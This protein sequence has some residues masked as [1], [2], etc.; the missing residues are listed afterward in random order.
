MHIRRCTV[1]LFLLFLLLTGGAFAQA[2][3]SSDLKCK[4]VS[5]TILGQRILVLPDPFSPRR[6]LA[7]LF[8]GKWYDLSRPKFTN[9]LISWRCP[10]CTPKIYPDVNE[11]DTLRFPDPDGVATRLLNVFS[12]TDS[13][14]RRVKVMSFNHS[15]Y[16]PDGIQTG[17]FSGGLLGFA[18][19]VYMDGNWHLARFQPAIAAYGAFSQAPKPQ[20]LEIAKGRYGFVIDHM[21]GGPGGPFW[22]DT[23]LIADVGGAFR[24]ILAAYGTARTAG[25]E[26]KSSWTATYAVISGVQRAF[27]DIVITCKGHFVAPDPERL[28]PELKKKVKA[29]QQGV[30]TI[31]HLY[32][33]Y[34]KEGYQEKPPAKVILRVKR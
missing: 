33:Y 32:V 13:N 34:E 3:P 20:P 26:G 4:T 25:F 23:Y 5:D 27:R 18:T 6:A 17:R 15:S 19:F 16:D 11:M 31:R 2:P 1:V 24:Q 10:R 7:R 8:P 9:R 29:G 14:G 22:Q 12:C 30:F 21:N 28:P